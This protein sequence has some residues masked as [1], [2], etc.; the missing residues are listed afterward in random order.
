MYKVFVNDKPL[1]LTNEIS[2]ETD[3]QLF[4]LESIDIEQLIIKIFQNKIQKAILYHPD[5]SEI[6][7]TLKAKI[8]VNKAGGGFVYNKKGEV[9]FIFRN[10]KWDLPKG[11]IEKGE[12]IEATA[13]RE[14]EEETGVNQLR[15]TN[16]LQKTYHI[17][18]RNGKY[19]LKITHWFEMQSDF[20]GTPH[21]QIEEGIEK[22]A[23]LNPDQIK[24]ALKNSYEN[25]KLLFEE[26]KSAPVDL[27]SKKENLES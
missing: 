16:K 18:K 13:M 14:V 5:E 17:F 24:E 21:G 8:P 2:R 4:L 27:K 1:F 10:G 3:F 23:W 19:K 26:D 15:I 6:M 12:D 22:V 7:K 9:L 11:G 25:I 20:E